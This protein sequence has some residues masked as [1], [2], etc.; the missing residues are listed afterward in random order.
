MADPRLERLR[1]IDAAAKPA[2]WLV[3]DGM[4]I[5]AGADMTPATEASAD[6]IATARNILP[7]LVDL[8]EVLLYPHADICG[9]GCPHHEGALAVLDRIGSDSDQ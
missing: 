5:S 1:Q 3:V 9:D 7:A 8:L 2:P 4:V 6:V